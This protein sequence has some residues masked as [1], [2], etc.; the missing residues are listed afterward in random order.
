M[1]TTE[2]AA[3]NP[4]EKVDC[5]HTAWW[6]L[7][8]FGMTLTGL[9]AYNDLVWG[10]WHGV[11]GDLLPRPVIVGIFLVAVA[12]HVCE[13]A[14]AYRLAVRS[15]RAATAALWGAQTL[16]LG[17]ASLSLLKKQIKRG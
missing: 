4:A 9:L 13:A 10:A 12:I 8:L 3:A 17:I 15:G 5:P 7:I 16:L 2:Q 6:V 1:Q 11:V 14:Y